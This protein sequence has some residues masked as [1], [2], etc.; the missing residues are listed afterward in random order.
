MATVVTL[1]AVVG[2]ISAVTMGSEMLDIAR[3]QTVAMQIIRNEIDG[4]HLQNWAMVSGTLPVS[5]TVTINDNGTDFTVSTG[6]A[7]KQAFALTNY[8]SSPANYNLGLMNVAKGFT[9]S[10]TKSATSQA[11]L[12]ALTYTVT[13]NGGNMRKGYSRSSVTYYGKTGLNLYYQK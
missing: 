8:S 11:N 6:A 7:D 12:W 10:L 9:L 4:I 2:L 5:A 13:W 1:V 3:K